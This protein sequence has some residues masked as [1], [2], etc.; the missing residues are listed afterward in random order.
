MKAFLMIGQSNMAGRGALNDLSE[1]S[2]A[3]VWMLRQDEWTEA[4]EPVTLDKPQLA[5]AGLG[6]T[7][8]I[9]VHMLTGEDVGLIP[10]SLGGTGLDAWM[11]ECDLYEEAVRRAVRAM[12]S[13]AVL[14]GV[15]WHQGENDS[16]Y[17]DKA[18]TYTKRLRR[19][20]QALTDRLNQEA[21]RMEDKTRILSP[22]PVL[23]G[24]LGDYLDDN[25]SSL[26]H[27]AV[28]EQLH[29]FAALRPEYACVQASDLPDKGD[30]LHF[31]TLS[32]RRLGLRYANA[33]FDTFISQQR[34]DVYRAMQHT[35][36]I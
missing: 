28:N 34:Q 31:S 35:D 1:L 14:S 6:L 17:F 36:Y 9:A 24:E 29:A 19:M 27:R 15:L 25:A 30:A 23:V 22:L 11:P 8:G 3:H 26:Y 20:M 12:N 13:G 7:F 33:W 2:S 5:G 32:Q 10:A 16:K 18:F 4:R 21:E